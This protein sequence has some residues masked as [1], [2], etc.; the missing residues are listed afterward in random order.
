[1][2]EK[3]E[4]PDF[5]NDNQKAQKI[6]QEASHIEKQINTW[7]NLEKNCLDSLELMN[8]VGDSELAEI[9]KDYENLK[10]IF[11]KASLEIYLNGE[12][13]NSNAILSIHAGTGGVD[14]QD[15]AEMLMRMYLRYGENQGLKTEILE[16]T[17]AEEA[18]IKSVAI[19]FTGNLAYGYLKNEHGVHR[20]VRLSPFN[21]KHSRETSF[22]LVEIIPEIDNEAEIEIDPNDLRIDTFRAG[23]A[24]G[25]NVNK[26]ESAIRI[27]HIPSGI[28]TQCQTERSQLQNKQ[29]ALKMLQGKLIQIKEENKLNSINEIKGDFKQGSWGNQ[30]RSYVLQ[31]Y[32]MVKDHRTNFET[33]QVDKVLDGDMVQDFI[34]AKLKGTAT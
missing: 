22:V 13:D 23:G 10:S 31:P 32:Q 28:V 29:N 27:T 2:K 6:L 25:Q 30:I 17:E 12:F 8:M 5:W 15:F 14:A 3:S 11:D 19:K 1:M 18:G 34:E 7:E 26:V 9:I 21:A 20:L 24:G 33:S 16:K 4:Q